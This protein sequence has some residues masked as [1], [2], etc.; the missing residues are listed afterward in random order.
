MRVLI[1]GGGIAGL[2]L[3]AKLQRQGREPVVIER[4]TEYAD[5]GYG[6]GL[7]PLGSCVLHGLGAYD[8]YLARGLE[9]SRY[10][11]ADH[12]GKLLQE[13]DLR[14]L[15]EDLGPMVML[16][17]TDLVD[18]LRRT[19]GDLPIRM[20]TTVEAVEQDAHAV[21]VTLSDG[22]QD[23]FD[24]VVGCDGIHSA[25]RSRMFDKPE[26]FD[27]KWTIWTWW[28]SSGLVP[29]DVFREY[30]GRG[31]FFGAYPVPQRCMYVAGLPTHV[32]ADH[33]APQENVRPLVRAA[34]AGLIDHVP[35][36]GTTLDDAETLFG[37]PMTDV[38]AKTWYRGRVALC[39][40]SAAAFLPTAGVGASNAMRA[41]AALAD[42]LSK[43]DAAHVTHALDMYEKRCRK[44]IEGNQNDS[45]AAARIMFVESPALGWA[46]DQIVKIYPA[47]RILK[48]IIESMRQPF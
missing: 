15:T 40:D 30:W 36:V 1:V 28:G 14:V 37:W 33:R 25:L 6:I 18:I 5:I 27:A 9:L 39:G 11:L 21:Y 13:L 47:R 8:E 23:D 22:T 48:R 32:A 43:T 38:R 41:A 42:E 20:G 35:K 34:L 46:R 12:T 31:A 29:D 10:E 2:V 16:S 4:A 3:A 24:L 17:R 44:I 19:C 26:V 7:Y 45:R